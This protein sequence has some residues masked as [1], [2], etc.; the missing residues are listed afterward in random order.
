MKQEELKKIAKQIRQD[1][2]KMTWQ[3][4]GAHLGGAL[5]STDL[6]VGLFMGNFKQPNDHFILS[7]GHV[8]PAYY[9]VLARLGQFSQEKL[10]NLRKMDSGLEGH[11]VKGWLPGLEATSGS[12]GHGLGLGLG[13]SL[14]L[15]LK[16]K[17]NQV[18]VMLGDG[19]HQEGSTWEAI[20]A[21]GHYQTDNLKVIV[22]RN[23][24]QIGGDTEKQMKLE[25]LAKKYRDFGWQVREINGHDYKQILN[26][27]AWLKKASGQPAV[28][29]G[30]TVRGKGI[31]FL[32]N[33][34]RS[35]SVKFESKCEYKKAL[36]EVN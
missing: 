28:L 20:M 5:S 9:A 31:S 3:A 7:N 32:E 14:G 21:A 22:D 19:D 16:K 27:L 23:K 25:P 26:G 34:D 17:L 36:K 24:M 15:K 4:G 30:F 1:V 29:I 10:K 12:L 18:F 11:P 13:L 8:C 33:T 2:V 35:H 6:L